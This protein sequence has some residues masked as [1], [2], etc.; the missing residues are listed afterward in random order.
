MPVAAAATVVLT[1]SSED[2]APLRS[3]LQARGVAVLE[4][5]TVDVR[6]VGPEPDADTVDRWLTD[7]RVAAF[8]SRNGVLSFVKLLGAP[9]LTA[10]Q[11]GGGIIAAVGKSTAQVLQSEGIE[12]V[13]AVQEPM[14][15]SHLAQVLAE[16]LDGSAGPVLAFQGRH[17]RP[18]LVDGLRQRGIEARVVVV[19]ENA[20]PAAPGANLLRACAA[21]SAIF[22]A[23]PSAADRLLAWA[24]EL[25]D[26][27]FVA[28]GPTTAAELLARHGIEA[29]TVAA[30]PAAAAVLYAIERALSL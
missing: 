22:V 24:P 13:V 9:R 19:Y 20:V 21:A 3:A 14:T 30:S 10:L 7:A 12:G 5:P 2:N 15:G 4:V 17:A 25:R 8:T 28:I 11:R 26:R 16:R 18:E 1:R 29:A 27:P 23:A 6:A